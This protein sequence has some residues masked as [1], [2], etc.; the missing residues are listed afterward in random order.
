MT[1]PHYA[2]YCR[3]LLWQ[4]R[5]A[6]AGRLTLNVLAALGAAGWLALVAGL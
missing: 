6:R 2:A 1:S 5:R 3:T 4:R